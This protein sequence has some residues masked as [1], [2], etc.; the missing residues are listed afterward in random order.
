MASR[1][2]ENQIEDR[3]KPE[4]SHREQP[5]HDP[6][7]GDLSRIFISVQ[8]EHR[9]SGFVV[10]WFIELLRPDPIACE[11]M[12]RRGPRP[13]AYG[14]VVRVA[15]FP[16]G[17]ED[18]LVGRSTADEWALDPRFDFSGPCSV[19]TFDQDFANQRI[20][21]APVE[22]TLDYGIECLV[23]FGRCVFDSPLDNLSI[24]QSVQTYPERSASSAHFTHNG[25]YSRTFLPAHLTY[26]PF[27]PFA[28]PAKWSGICR[29][30][31]KWI[32]NLRASLAT[33]S[34]RSL[35]WLTH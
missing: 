24:P 18:D 8:L 19:D 3:R 29:S 4:P 33:G 30:P 25:R 20:V 27:P 16:L 5:L 32:K 2:N 22:V 10:R 28:L 6:F 13:R 15:G 34:D 23:P 14:L 9:S 11:L 7:L 21:L 31:R 35:P 26:T 1:A 12:D 17:L